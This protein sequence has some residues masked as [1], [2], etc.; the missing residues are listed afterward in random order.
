M[1]Y[2]KP[3]EGA[4]KPPPDPESG[5]ITPRTT[6]THG[7]A[8]ADSAHNV[9]VASDRTTGGDVVASFVAHVTVP[10]RGDDD[11]IEVKVKRGRSGRTSGGRSYTDDS[12]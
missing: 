12:T 7:S 3:D 2:I 8:V 4:P 10:A 6:E 5:P 9:T 1:P 11:E